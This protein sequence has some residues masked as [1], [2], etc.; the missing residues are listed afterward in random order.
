MISAEDKE[1]VRQAT[2]FVAL[3]S[4]TVVL[5]QKSGGRDF[6]GRCPFHSEKTASFH[7]MPD[8]GL[9]K[10]FSC[11]EGGDVFAYVMKREGLEFP[12]AIRYLADRAGIELV[13]ESGSAR[14]G[15]K[16]SRLSEA[17]AEAEDFYHMQLTRSRAEGAARARSYLSGRG[18][19]LEVCKRWRL[20]YAPGRGALVAH[21][22]QKGFSPAEIEAAN[23]SVSRSGRAADRFYE[24]AMFPIHDELGKTI[25]FGGRV[26]GSGEPKYLNSNENAV[27]HKSKAL[28]ALDRA[29]ES[30]TA[31]GE[32]IVVEGYTDAIALHESGFTQTVATLGTALT[33]D[34]V[35]L[36]S[37][38]GVKRIIFMFDGDAAGQR[39]AERTVQ[40]IDRCDA[41]ML[42]VCL[43]GGLDPAEYIDAHGA[44]ALAA[45]LERGVPLMDFV[46]AKRFEGVELD[47][48]GKR[49]RMLDDMA[50]VLAPL[51][52]SVLLDEYAT[53]LADML[54]L[55][56]DDVRSAI[57]EKPVAAPERVREE[58]APAPAQSVRP[59][60][61]V[62]LS[63]EERKQAGA[64][65]ELIAAI[66][67]SPEAARAHSERIAA[68]TWADAR[69]EAMA[70]AM[71]STPSGTSP[72][73]AVAAAASVV[74][75]APQIIAS[76][77]TA[78]DEAD[79]RASL[80]F[81]LDVAELFSSKRR[82][83]EIRSALKSEGAREKADA[84]FEEATAL[85]RRVNELQISLSKS[86]ST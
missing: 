9:F 41:S 83:R 64:E 31:K 7:V 47:T 61:P 86:M 70:W 35:K 30:I 82:I 45:E 28:F 4:E 8:T 1:R 84:L 54:G 58:P 81:A 51:K 76:A 32:A 65:R 52:A 55:R 85:Q 79:A 60:A 15:P 78:A 39:A 13:E 3:V 14:S 40:F 67:S 27:F 17:L 53:R 16:R 74:A 72:A 48:P 23:L 38:Y 73:D 50:G 29:K 68:L 66:A 59:A 77:R 44:A 25:G 75:E 2:D 46:F 20:G 22:R 63:E 42:C 56:V 6:W 10:C 34:H 36:L 12:D 26:L 24:R 11:G 18:F 33:G 71:L 49:V 5:T 69:N 43:P 62:V 19:G 57:K 37:R 80:G 21:L